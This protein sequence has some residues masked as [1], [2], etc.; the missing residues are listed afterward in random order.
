MSKRAVDTL[1]II[2]EGIK[3]QG[4]ILDGEFWLR[5]IQEIFENKIKVKP[6]T[7][8]EFDGLTNNS[9][10]NI[11]ARVLCDSINPDGV[12]LTT[13]EWRYPRFIH[14]EIMT[15][16]QLSRNSASSRAIPLNKMIENVT[17]NPVFKIEWGKNQKGM[18]ASTVEELT[19]EQKLQCGA[20][21][22]TARDECVEQ[23]L[24]LQQLG[25]HKQVGN[26][27]LEPWMWITVIVSATNFE[28]VFALRCHP[29][30]E[31]HF[32]NLAYKVRDVFDASK[33]KNLHWG[34]WHLPL[35][36]GYDDVESRVDTKGLWEQ[37][38]K[39]SAG[40]CAR[41][42]YLTHEGKRDVKE[43]VALCDRLA[44]H[45]PMHASPLEHPAKAVR[46]DQRIGYG[47]T[48]WGNYDPGWLQLRK[49]YEGE[50]VRVRGEV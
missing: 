35:V 25:V 43:D 8:S 32:Q 10:N 21:W 19:Q 40:R 28:N 33:P 7:S 37:M 5:R 18:Q 11:T 24:A 14:S 12:R 47:P 45:R 26:R 27:L 16:R 44:T 30:A 4:K 39:V 49:Y 34:E 48:D 29:D 9:K 2:I 13:F 3:G 20:H 41:V 23:A 6:L 22:L 31:P 36:R 42:S 50:C 15:H 38:A 46:Q 17:G 1:K